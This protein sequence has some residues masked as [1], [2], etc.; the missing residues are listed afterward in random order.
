MHTQA[1]RHAPVS[2]LA[3]FSGGLDSILAARL[4]VEQGIE[5]QC[6][7]F[8]SPF[9][10]EVASIPYWERT[11]GLQVS[12]VDL[13]EEFVRMMRQGP[14]N[15]FGKV[16]NPC[17]DCKIMMIR[18]ARDL[19]EARGASFVISGE[20]LGQRP[21]SQR[22][23]TLNLIRKEAGADAWL[24]RPLSA[25]HLAPTPMEEQGLVDRE[26]L[27]GFSGRGRK[28]QLALAEQFG[29]ADI[30]TPAGGCR[31]TERENA[32]RYW[33]L[34]NN[35][36]A[37]AHDFHLANV[38]RQV[39]SVGTPVPVWLS[40]GRNM[41]DNE[42]LLALA[43]PDDVLFKIAELPGPIALARHG[44][45]WPESLLQDAA[46]YMASFSPKAVAL[47]AP[48]QV[49]LR[50]NGDE[51]RVT[52]RPERTPQ[53]GWGEFSVDCVREHVRAVNCALDRERK[54]F[55]SGEPRG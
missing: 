5:V 38:G 15:G 32:R 54:G 23:D 46:A 22:R 30:P 40:V 35:P 36:E 1:T 21:M 49:N 41:D 50:Q 44:A 12:A 28:D 48:V 24:L 16:L 51:R 29:L 27:R 3:L 53:S 34:L 4:L 17:V 11:F 52:V 7:H 14:P 31:L 8:T 39:W 9:F 20:V 42:R 43:R 45:I 37:G 47:D 6:I 26:R 33:P 10:G 25:L 18:R 13:S 55:S 19:M 2:A